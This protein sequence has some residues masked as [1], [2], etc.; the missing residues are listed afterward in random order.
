MTGGSDKKF[1]FNKRG[2]LKDDEI[3]ELARTNKNIFSWLKPTLPPMPKLAKVMET[4]QM[5]TPEDMDVVD[6]V[7][8]ER[9]ERVR[10][11]QLEWVGQMLCKGLVMELVDSAVMES[12]MM[13]CSSWLNSTLL[14]KCWSTLEERRIMFELREG[15]EGTRRGVEIGLRN[16][17]EGEEAEVA[18]LLEEEAMLRRHEKVERLRLAW[19]RKMELRK[20]EGMMKELSK[21]SLE[22]L[23]R[24][25]ESIELLVTKM[26]IDVTGVYTRGVNVIEMGDVEMKDAAKDISSNNVILWTDEQMDTASMATGEIM[27]E[28]D[29][30]EDDIMRPDTAQEGMTVDTL[31]EVVGMLPEEEMGMVETMCTRGDSQPDELESVV[32]VESSSYYPHH[33]GDGHTPLLS[34]ATITEKGVELGCV[35]GLSIAGEHPGI[36]IVYTDRDDTH[37]PDT[38]PKDMSGDRGMRPVHTPSPGPQCKQRITVNDCVLLSTGVQPTEETADLRKVKLDSESTNLE[39]TPVMVEGKLERFKDIGS[40]ITQWEDLEH[41]DKEWMVEEGV[42]WGGRKFSRR[43]SELIGIFGEENDKI[44]GQTRGVVFGSDTTLNLSSV[45][46]SV[47]LIPAFHHYLSHCIGDH[48]GGAL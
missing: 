41:N 26:M 2:K 19:K 5:D 28:E 18:L 37:T 32:G 8:E 23:D 36:G 42:R 43:M 11:R 10:L 38:G 9:L 22:D 16:I 7:R 35:I 44:V 12:E 39:R 46:D 45:S 48:L 14:D 13:I 1:V 6:T 3:V 47:C 17:R 33:Y 30:V 40:M 21:L 31:L 29:M 34:P 15:D 25:M 20:Y 4:E 27:D 24:D